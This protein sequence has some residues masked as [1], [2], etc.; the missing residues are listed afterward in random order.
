MQM[1]SK[2]KLFRYVFLS[3]FILRSKD[4]L[5]KQLIKISGH[6]KFSEFNKFHICINNG[7]NFLHDPM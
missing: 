7:I 4:T 1:I 5:C 2:Y 3:Y 6:F